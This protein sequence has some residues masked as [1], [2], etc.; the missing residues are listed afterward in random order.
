MDKSD[1][2][3]LSALLKK[4]APYFEAPAAL[5]ERV[6]ASLAAATLPANE[7]TN[8]RRN[9]QGG[10]GWG[11]G[12]A[13]GVLLSV[14]V[15]VINGGSR[16]SDYVL[17]QVVDGHV[18]SLMGTHLADVTSSDR[19]T[20]KPW[21]SGKLDF[22]PPVNDYAEQGFPLIGGRLDYIN[23]RPVA[24]LVYRHR[25]HTINVFIWPAKNSETKTLA[26]VIRKGINVA[27]WQMNGLQFWAVSDLGAGDLE[28]LGKIIRE[29]EK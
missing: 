25:L 22:S 7:K 1:D 9:W 10:L 28:R 27:A 19:H 11:L 23:E 2:A 3:E 16:Q 13:L 6:T 26:S 12:F 15:V 4:Q 18:R 8:S 21:F 20:V 29:S 14:V 17:T 5:R 24:A